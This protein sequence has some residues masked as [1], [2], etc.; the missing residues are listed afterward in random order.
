MVIVMKNK[1]NL[2]NLI[3]IIVIS[4]IFV[5]SIIYYYNHTIIRDAELYEVTPGCYAYQIETAELNNDLLKITGWCFNKDESRSDPNSV[6]RV[7]IV[8]VDTES[9]SDFH[10]YKA[11][12]GI[13][14]EDVNN[15]YHNGLDYTYCG[16]E[17]EINLS[18]LDINNKDYEILIQPDVS[19]EHTIRPDLFLHEGCIMN[20]VSS[21]P[22]AIELTGTDLT[23][24]V[25]NGLVRAYLPEIGAFVYQYNWKVYYLLDEKYPINDGWTRLEFNVGT[26]C[27][28]LLSESMQEYEFENLGFNVSDYEITDTLY[29]GKY[30]VIV[31]ELPVEYPITYVDTG[32]YNSSNGWLWRCRFCPG[33]SGN[34][35]N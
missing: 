18:K 1:K 34:D 33:I 17:T 4:I 30:R 10:Y 14:R 26:N 8:L 16:F 12:C 20:T 13:P 25:N 31:H 2:P 24:I 3:V 5:I 15:Y 23:E 7:R 28:E 19:S 9:Y 35:G 21:N 22:D 6:P 11:D 27:P 29:A 32:Y